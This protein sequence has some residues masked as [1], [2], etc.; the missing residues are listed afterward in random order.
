MVIRIG[1][2]TQILAMLEE[3]YKNFAVSPHLQ[4]TQ[5]P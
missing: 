2:A 1:L 5:Q 3:A 4:T